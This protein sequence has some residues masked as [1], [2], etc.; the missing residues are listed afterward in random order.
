MGDMFA[1][2]QGSTVAPDPKDVAG[3]NEFMKRY[4][5]GLVIE[6]AAVDNLK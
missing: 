5:R 4:T 6:R 1:G 2:K 3:F